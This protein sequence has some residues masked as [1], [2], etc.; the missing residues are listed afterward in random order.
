MITCAKNG[1]SCLVYNWN[2]VSN[3][4]I[5]AY[6]LSSL[7]GVTDMHLSPDGTYCCLIGSYTA[8]LFRKNNNDYNYVQSSI[9]DQGRSF[10][11]CDMSNNRLVYIGGNRLRIMN[12][13]SS[14]N[15]IDN[16]NID[17]AS[18]VSLVC[19]KI[20]YFNNWIFVGNNAS[21]ILIYS[22]ISGSS[23]SLR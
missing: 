15:F 18:S 23:Y 20:S 12:K 14:G 4:Y 19:I 3:Q 13:N 11:R 10:S 6:N 16:Q 1:T 9:N 22:I 21:Q 2:N 7:S 5:Q 17:L 8:N